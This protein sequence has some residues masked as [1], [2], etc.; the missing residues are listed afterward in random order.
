[1]NEWNNLVVIRRVFSGGNNDCTVEKSYFFCKHNQMTA[2][3]SMSVV[4]FL[5][6]IRNIR[7]MFYKKK[8]LFSYILGFYIMLMYVLSN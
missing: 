6:A 2:L 1:M 3:F 8:H 5:I 4:K 7:E